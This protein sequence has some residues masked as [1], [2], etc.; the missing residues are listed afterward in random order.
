MK[1][2]SGI[3]RSLGGVAGVAADLRLS[4]QTVHSWLYRGFPAARGIEIR[5]LARRKGVRL[6]IDQIMTAQAEGS[7]AVA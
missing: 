1:T 2:V 4:Y 3:L 7:D 6:T 5:D